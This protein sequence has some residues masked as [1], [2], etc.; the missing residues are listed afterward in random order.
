[1]GKVGEFIRSVVCFHSPE[2]TN[3]HIKK[4]VLLQGAYIRQCSGQSKRACL[5]AYKC[6]GVEGLALTQSGFLPLCRKAKRWC[7]DATPH[8]HSSW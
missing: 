7:S 6:N 8:F 1:M 4:A 3:L 5:T 2:A